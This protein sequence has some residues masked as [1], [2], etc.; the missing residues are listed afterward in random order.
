MRN[1]TKFIWI[2][3]FI[4]RIVR[5]RKLK[6]KISH[7]I[8]WRSNAVYIAEEGDLL[9]T[10]LQKEEEEE[11][12]KMTYQPIEN[13][14]NEEGYKKQNSGKINDSNKRKNARRNKWQWVTKRD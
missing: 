8:F 2:I 7:K 5:N 11:A 6:E 14:I 1:R 13:N 12:I 9:S 4:E 10:F 3:V